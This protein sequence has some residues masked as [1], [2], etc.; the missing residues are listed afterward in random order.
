MNP[1]AVGVKFGFGDIFVKSDVMDFAELT[2]FLP[3]ITF[4]LKALKRLLIRKMAEESMSKFMK[5]KKAKV[6]VGLKV[7]DRLLRA[8]KELA[9][10]VEGKLWIGFFEGIKKGEVAF[11]EQRGLF[12]GTFRSLLAA[13]IIR[14]N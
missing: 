11:G 12:V 1:V 10:W 8:K 6:F 13:D 5:E 3:S 14:V 4:Y 2:S 7:I 9:A